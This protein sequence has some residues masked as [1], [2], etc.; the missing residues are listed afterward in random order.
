MARVACS[1][2]TVWLGRKQSF[3]KREETVTTQ[4]VVN[5]IY[6][7]RKGS[8]EK[9]AQNSITQGACFPSSFEKSSLVN[10]S[11]KDVEK[12]RFKPSQKQTLSVCSSI[13]SKTFEFLMTYKRKSHPME[14]SN[15]KN[16]KLC[17]RQTLLRLSNILTPNTRYES[18]LPE[19]IIQMCM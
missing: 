7:N 8:K 17:I 15:D 10:I 12:L 18:S 11:S 9:R 6:W 1:Q 13:W 5:P 2:H 16:K 4:Q 14:S 19:W 3:H